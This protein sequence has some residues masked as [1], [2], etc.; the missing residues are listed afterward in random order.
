MG[1]IGKRDLYDQIDLFGKSDHEQYDELKELYD[2]YCEIGG[3]PAVVI[4]Y[5]ETKNITNCRKTLAQIIRIFIEESTRYFNSILEISLFE[6]LFPSIAQLS[7][8]EKKG[9][10][11]LI[12]ELS[13]II[14]KEDSNKVT[15]QSLNHAIVW[16]YRS[17]IIDYCGKAIEC[18]SMDTR[19]NV[20]F[21]FMDI[22]LC[23]YFL[24]KGGAKA[25]A[26]AGYLNE[27]FVYL[28]LLKRTRELEISGTAPMF[29]T[30]KTGEIDFFV[31][32]TSNDKNYGVEVK[33]GKAKGKTAELLLRDGKVEAVY[34]LKGNTYGGIEKRMITV[35]IYLMSRVSFDFLRE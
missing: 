25:E 19:H 15:K 17:D 24:K 28:D 32:N 5:F 20:R 12:G 18:D 8:R 6:Q 22:G 2:V 30:Y 9:S 26:I 16:L 1:A 35:P 7:V 21:Y 23:R 33:A 29:G 14:Y 27:N 4:E 13:K 3:Y 10:D 11:D 31:S 34:F